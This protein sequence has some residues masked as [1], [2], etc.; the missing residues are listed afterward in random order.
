MASAVAWLANGSLCAD[1]MTM[2][3]TLLKENP[4]PVQSLHQ[5]C[6]EVSKHEEE[7][8]LVKGDQN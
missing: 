5:S 6:K 4:Q 2:L 8:A 7:V 1:D 3:N